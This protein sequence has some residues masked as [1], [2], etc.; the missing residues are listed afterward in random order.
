MPEVDNIRHIGTSAEELHKKPQKEKIS[1][2]QQTHTKT[3]R[4]LFYSGLT[5]CRTG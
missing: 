5:N 2:H 3:A 4:S 1:E